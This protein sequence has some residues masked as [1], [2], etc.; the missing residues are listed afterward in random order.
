MKAITVRPPWAWL[1]VPE[2]FSRCPEHVRE[3]Y[4]R[5]R[6]CEN[7]SHGSPALQQ[8][9]HMLQEQGPFDLLI[10][11]GLH[12]EDE[13]CDHFG[14]HFLPVGRLLCVVEVHDIRFR[15]PG[16]GAD[17]RAADS[18]YSPWHTPLATAIYVRNPR[19]LETPVPW[20]G[21]LHLFD[22]PDD[23]FAIREPMEA[24]HE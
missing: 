8:A 14:L 6:D 2:I 11:V 17:D 24:L 13:W 1:F 3:Y 19:P 7:R 12:K 5:P 4:G 23:A 9:R 16:A 22:V 18:R 15:T 21:Q 10:H 20:R